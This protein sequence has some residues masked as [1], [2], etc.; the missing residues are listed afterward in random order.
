MH[1]SLIVVDGIVA[2]PLMLERFKDK[3]RDF[4]VEPLDIAGMALMLVQQP[5]S[6]WSF[7]VEA[8]PFAEPW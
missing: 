4:F 7:E 3:P 8:R 1:V 5:R 2:E 6:T